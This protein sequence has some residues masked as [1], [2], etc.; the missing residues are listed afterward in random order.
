LDGW[1]ELIPLEFRHLFAQ[2]EDQELQGVIGSKSTAAQLQCM[3]YYIQYSFCQVAMSRRLREGG[4]GADQRIVDVVRVRRS[5][6]FDKKI[7]E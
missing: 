7:Q 5:G 1:G 4:G 3:K 2:Q 6:G